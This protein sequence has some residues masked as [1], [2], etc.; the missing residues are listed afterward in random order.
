MA[1]ETSKLPVSLRAAHEHFALRIREVPDGSSL[2]N[3]DQMRS[4][5]NEADAVVFCFNIKYRASFELMKT[6]V[7]VAPISVGVNANGKQ[8]PDVSR[9]A[10]LDFVI[11]NA[12]SYGA[13][14]RDDAMSHTEIREASPCRKIVVCDATKNSMVLRLFHEAGS[15]ALQARIT[16]L[17]NGALSLG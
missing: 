17:Q 1:L 3:D 16:K 11:L 10:H 9:L 14:M 15:L 2:K 4:M 8:A 7:S 6:M 12:M 5:V 13:E